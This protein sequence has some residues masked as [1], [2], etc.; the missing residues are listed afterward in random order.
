MNDLDLG[1]VES[2]P[3]PD[4]GGGFPDGRPGQRV[5]RCGSLW[6]WGAH[7]TPDEWGMIRHLLA[8]RSDGACELCG[9]RVD[10]SGGVTGGT[11]HHRDARGMGGTNNPAI[12]DLCNLLLLCGGRLGGVVGCHGYTE[13]NRERAYEQG[14]LVRDG[15]DPVTVPVVLHNGARVRLARDLQEYLPLEQ[16]HPRHHPLEEAS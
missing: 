5:C 10:R 12:N 4:C 1:V 11:V 3:C 7:P 13:H 16:H 2:W 9:R 6:P 14:W 8:C 15:T